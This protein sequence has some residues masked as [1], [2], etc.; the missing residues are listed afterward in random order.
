MMMV[1]RVIVDILSSNR[2]EF[3]LEAAIRA[4]FTRMRKKTVGVSP[5]LAYVT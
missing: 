2:G 3:D 1:T 5:S 4:W